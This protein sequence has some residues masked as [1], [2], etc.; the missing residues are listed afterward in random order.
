MASTPP[1]PTGPTRR[2]RVVASPDLARRSRRRTCRTLWGGRRSDVLRDTE[3]NRWSYPAGSPSQLEEH[4]TSTLPSDT[5]NRPPTSASSSEPANKQALGPVRT[6]PRGQ[7]GSSLVRGAQRRRRRQLLRAPRGLLDGLDARRWIRRAVCCARLV[8]AEAV[9]AP[10]ER[11]L[12][13]D[14]PAAE[15]EVS[16]R[17]RARYGQDHY[18]W[19]LSAR[20]AAPRIRTSRD[21][22]PIPFMTFGWGLRH[23]CNA[24]R[25][26]G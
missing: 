15:A 22:L 13:S 9:R 12:R 10:D 26:S 18:G 17:G 16:A 23:H 14:A 2:L 11:C 25:G 24:C 4:P 19:T 3:W 8:A 21:A 20:N 1:E 6:V 7:C 5:P